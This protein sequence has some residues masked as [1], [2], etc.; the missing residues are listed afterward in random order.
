MK[1]K[2]TGLL[3][4]YDPRDYRVGASPIVSSTINPT[5]DWRDWRPSD[6][7]QYKE[8]TFDTLACASFSALNVLETTINFFIAKDMLT[9]DKI[10]WL[11]KNGY[12]V[13]GKI[14]ISDRFTAIMS[15]TT[16]LGNYMPKVWDSIRKD[17]VIPESDLPFGGNTQAEYLDVNQ[18][19]P[20]MKNKALKF[21]DIVECAYEWGSNRPE[22]MEN[23]LKECSPQIAVY[24]GTHAVQMIDKAFMFDTY[25]PFLN[26]LPIPVTY[27]LRAIIKVKVVQTTYPVLRIGSKG[28]AV[29]ELQRLL[30]VTAD[31]S[32]GPITL[33]VLIAFQRSHGLVADGIVGAKTWAELK[34]K[35]KLTLIQAIIQVESNGNDNAIGDLGL[36]HPAYGCMQIRQPLVIDVNRKF[37]TNYNAKDCLGNRALSIELFNKYF[38]IYSH[39]KTDEHKARAWNGGGNFH[40]LYGKKGYEKYSKNLDDYWGKV[41]KIL[42]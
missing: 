26:A 32:F 25:P 14:N 20:V 27:V 10:E 15:G 28:E 1:I 33:K 22:D 8:Y 9:I 11:N 31:G 40:L 12:I 35:S 13:D 38:E 16:S 17:G 5:G 36:K 2:Q 39:N 6:E 21:L 34:K 7:R 3:Y 23:Y 42:A 18:V 30:G 4:E 29:K 24:S 37:G 41:S 19:T